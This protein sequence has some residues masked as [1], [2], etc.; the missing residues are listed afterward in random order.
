[1]EQRH[2]TVLAPVHLPVRTA[3]YDAFGSCT[4]VGCLYLASS[5]ARR[6]TSDIKEYNNWF[7]TH[8]LCA[9]LVT[10]TNISSIEN[11]RCYLGLSE[12]I[13]NLI[14]YFISLT[15]S[16]RLVIKCEKGFFDF[17]QNK[18]SLFSNTRPDE[19]KAST[20][21]YYSLLKVFKSLNVKLLESSIDVNTSY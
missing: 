11:L 16:K 1:L 15:G 10:P 19:I 7:P 9:H 21:V 4:S 3:A 14:I 18:A 6:K 17:F 5:F 12:A 2:A 13:Y 20:I 8:V